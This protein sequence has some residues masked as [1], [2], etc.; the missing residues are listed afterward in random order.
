MMAGLIDYDRGEAFCG[1]TI[2][3]ISYAVTA[4]HCLAKR[5]DLVKRTGLLVGDWNLN[6]GMKLG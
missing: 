6:S 2:I 4:A 1:A 5:Q 3:A